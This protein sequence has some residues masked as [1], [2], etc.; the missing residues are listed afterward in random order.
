MIPRRTF[1]AG[2]GAIILAAPLA[3]EG[4]QSHVPRVGVLYPESHRC[5]SAFRQ[6]LI[7]LGYVEGRNVAFEYRPGGSI[8]QNIEQTGLGASLARSG[9]NITGISLPIQR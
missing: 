3:A 7:D 4:Q 9:G 8:E 1:L 6:G 5:V 2:T